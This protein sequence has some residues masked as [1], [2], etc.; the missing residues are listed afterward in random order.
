MEARGLSTA[1]LSAACGQAFSTRTIFRWKAGEA[2]PGAEA[3]PLLGSA[4][5][6]TID[7]LVGASESGGP[8]L[9]PSQE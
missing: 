5:G 3:L 8:S 6:V 2:V 4:L 9:D 7:W 1:A